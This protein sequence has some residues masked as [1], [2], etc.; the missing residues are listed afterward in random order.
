MKKRNLSIHEHQSMALLEKYGIPVPQGKLAHTAEEAFAAANELGAKDLVVKAQV[1]AG[2]RGKGIFES[3]LKGGVQL[4]ANSKV[5]KEMAARMIGS[6]LITKQTGAG[7]RPCNSVFIV[8][9][10]RSVKDYYLAIMLDRHTGGLML[11]G[12]S[13]GGMDIEAVAAEDPAAIITT[14]LPL[15][16]EPNEKV[17]A[18]F[19]EKIGINREAIPETIAIMKKMIRLF[20]EKDATLIEINPFIQTTNGRMFCLDAKINFDDNADFRQKELVNLRDPS[21]ED[22]R[23]VKASE[24]KLNYIGLDGHI[25]CLVNGAGLA[26]A[27]MDII[28][29][30]G[31]EP[32]NFLDVGGSATAAQ[33]EEA[34]KILGDDPSV[35][36]I[37]VNIFGGIMRCDI[38]AEG[39]LNAMRS[40]DFQI[41]I[42]VR[43]LGTNV[44]EAKKMMAASKMHVFS[45]DQLED[46]AKK[47]VIL[48]KIVELA[49]EGGL[50]ISINM[51]D[52]I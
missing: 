10:L 11:V 40:R 43:L 17:L 33:V 44:E 7:G 39:I 19:S 14:T 29:L 34:L 26:M 20:R 45:C 6:S 31:G 3:G 2:G 1:L 28:K 38:I 27:T 42:V 32:A 51:D 8:E 5:A 41:P 50:Q 36:A 13:R 4:V 23:E 12:S 37:L 15:E 47:A 25:G 46:A 16:G 48:A 30:Q 52:H 22:E 18:S 9:C 35:K 21:Q 49:K 24:H